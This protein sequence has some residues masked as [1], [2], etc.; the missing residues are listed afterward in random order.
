MKSF[1]PQ[2]TQEHIKNGAAG[3]ARYALEF[4]L[5][6]KFAVTDASRKK[7]A[8]KDSDGE[9]VYDTEGIKLSKKFFRIIKER[10]FK[11]VREL[12]NDIRTRKDDAVDRK[13]QVECDA[14]DELMYKLDDYRKGVKDASLEEESTETNALRDSFI[15]CL[16]L[17][18]AKA[19]S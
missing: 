19:S 11:L 6:D 1:L 10:N 14:C 7:L 15:K 4:P 3:Y 8:W 9:M 13:D 12:M 18:S 5:K 2:L 16:C 17:M